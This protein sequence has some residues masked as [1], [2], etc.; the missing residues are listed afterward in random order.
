VLKLR[1]A[2]IS[3][4]LPPFVSLAF[5]IVAAGNEDVRSERIM[6]RFHRREFVFDFSNRLIQLLQGI[7]KATGV[8]HVQSNIIGLNVKVARS[9]ARLTH[10]S[11]FTGLTSRSIS[12]LLHQTPVGCKTNA[13]FLRRVFGSAHRSGADRTLDRAEEARA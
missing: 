3:R 9:S 12:R 13:V 5:L 4:R 2:L 1:R 10:F 11:V 7:V 6:V 8:H